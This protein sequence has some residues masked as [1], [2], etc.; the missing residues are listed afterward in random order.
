MDKYIRCFLISFLII[1]TELSAQTLSKI[2]N[3]PQSVDSVEIYRSQ[4][5]GKETWERIVSF[6]G[7]AVSMP[8]VLFFKMQE[9]IVGYVYENKLIPKTIDFFTSVDEQRG[10]EPTYSSRSGGGI[11]FFQKGILNPEF[12][13]SLKASGS[14]YGRQHYQME[15]K[16]LALYRDLLKFRIMGEYR[17]LLGEAF[18]GIGPK[19]R[20]GNRTDYDHELFAAESDFGIQLGKKLMLITQVGIDHH[21]IFG[22]S[23]SVRPSIKELYNEDALPG[24]ESGVQISRFQVGFQYDSKNRIGNPS[25]GKE[26]N[27]AATTFQD[28]NDA[29]Y[30]F[31]KISA[32]INQYVHLFRNRVIAFSITGE[33]TEP[34]E[35]RQIPFYYLSSFG[36]HETIRGFSRGRFRDQDMLLGSIEYRIPLWHH[37][38][39]NLFVDAGQVSND[40][41]NNFRT[42]KMQFGYGIG[43][44]L[45]NSSKLVATLEFAF[46]KE[47]FRVYFE[48]N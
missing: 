5:K 40:I 3:T 41:F 24:L 26:M 20:S 6:P 36:R 35:N 43:W 11:K 16:R 37:L 21:N 13:L 28:M 2:S 18:Y 15:F 32:E 22:H 42:D 38:D 25:S 19:T 17:Y 8:L 45:W 44:R 46:S 14:F 4:Y 47:R 31:W 39:T 1:F 9:Q 33:T 48:L 7:T 27:F 12:K 30:S 23:G 10:I 29:N 34:Y